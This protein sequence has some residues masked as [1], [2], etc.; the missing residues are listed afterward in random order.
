MKSKKN[1]LESSALLIEDSRSFHNSKPANDYSLYSVLQ[2][3]SEGF[4]SEGSLYLQ[5][6]IFHP[7]T[8]PR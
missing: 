5:C 1:E 8:W 7:H 2:R 6:E 3:N 4:L